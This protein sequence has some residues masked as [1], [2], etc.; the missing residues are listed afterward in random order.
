MQ[1]VRRCPRQQDARGRQLFRITIAATFLGLTAGPLA[2][3]DRVFFSRNFPGSVPP[4]FEALV[5]S[6]GTVEYREEPGEDPVVVELSQEETEKVFDLAATLERFARPVGKKKRK[7]IAS[8]GKKVLRF[9]SGD[10]T[11]GEVAF[12]YTEDLDYR[13]IT[14]F[15]VH[16]AGTERHLFDLETT[17]QFDRLGVNKA[18]LAF[19]ASYDDGR[20]ISPGQFVPILKK[21]QEQEKIIHMARS[22]AASLIEAIER[23]Q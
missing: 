22:R 15:F 6:A 12:D 17:Y 10:T 18:L 3:E 19:H 5:T 11:V 7:K 1:P 20:I 13:A 23:S 14:R 4:Y 16:L 9:E 21:I 8:T 2:A